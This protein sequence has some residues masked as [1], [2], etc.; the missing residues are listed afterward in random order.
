MNQGTTRVGVA[1][2]PCS[3]GDVNGA[4]KSHG[5]EWS[6]TESMVPVQRCMKEGDTENIEF[7]GIA[8]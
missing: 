2:W 8:A 6:L 1:K 5:D 7:V 3:G 4:A